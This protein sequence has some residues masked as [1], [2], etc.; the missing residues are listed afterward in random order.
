MTQPVT[1]VRKENSLIDLP[2]VSFVRAG[3]DHGGMT[4]AVSPVLADALTVNGV[5][6]WWPL[7]RRKVVLVGFRTG[8]LAEAVKVLAVML[9]A[10]WVL[11]Q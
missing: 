11:G 2:T 1:T 10:G 3:P 7:S 6:M 9:G 5:P 4:G 8:G